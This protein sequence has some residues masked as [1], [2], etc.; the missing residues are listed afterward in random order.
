MQMNENTEDVQV[1]DNEQATEGNL[2]QNDLL[3]F[4]SSESTNEEV[5]EPT[6]E[7]GGE[8]TKSEAVLSQSEE[9]TSEQPEEVEANEA[10]E[11]EETQPKSVQKLL[12]QI[13]RLTARAKG[14]EEKVEALSSQLQSMNLE[15]KVEENPTIEEVQSFDDLEKLRKEA[16]SAKKWARS[17]ED[18]NYVQD[19]DKEYTREQIKKIR[20]SA[21]EHLE[22]LIPE[23]QKFLQL[24]TSSEQQALEDFPSLKQ[25][26]SRE[27]EILATMNADKNLK[28]LDKLPNGLYLKSLMIEG[29][30]SVEKKRAPKARI[31]KPKAIGKP[32][33]APT[34]DTSPPVRNTTSDSDRRKK[35][36]GDSNISENQ[37]S[38]FLS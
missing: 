13:N 27:L 33:M 22:E 31:K 21:E 12:K 8:E 14:S 19:G 7:S 30:L 15:K 20:D 25:E 2:T 36:L 18:E 23:R 6:D 5:P 26:G 38:A 24:K 37:L 16:L 17:H 32:P 34:G 10:E 35:I 1:A 3:N 4:L 28:A 9:E 11:D 29:I